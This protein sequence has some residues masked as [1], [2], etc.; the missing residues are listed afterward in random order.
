[1]G[2]NKRGPALAAI[3]GLCL[4]AACAV[5]ERPP[6][7]PLD[8]TP[9][10]LVSVRPDS[11]TTGLGDTKVLH[12]TFSEKM[13]RKSA[14]S[15]LFFYPDQMVRKTKWDGA[16]E[17]EVFLA[18][19]LPPDTVIVIEV[20]AGQQDMHR[21]PTRR[22]RS[23][24]LATA[25]ELPPGAIEG[26]LAMGDSA[27][28]RGV[29]EL[30][31][32]PPDS[33]EYF[34]QRLLRRATTDAEGKFRFD[35]LPAPGGPWLLR[36][37]VDF[38]RDRRLAENEP[39]RLLP[40]TVRVSASDP[41]VSVG[42][43]T[44][45]ARNTPGSLLYDPFPLPAWPGQVLAWT[46][47]VSESDT[48]WAPRPI[49]AGMQIFDLLDPVAGGEIA[50]VKPGDLRLAAFVDVDGDSTFSAISDSVL[51]LAPDSEPG[52]ARW[53]LEPWQLVEGLS[54]EPGLQGKLTMSTFPDSLTPWV[55]PP[56]PSTI[57]ETAADSL[58]SLEDR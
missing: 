47:A 18:E 34:Q 19:V 41:R 20:A 45:Y 7:G 50:Q 51:G 1:M 9:P 35:W 24:P 38:N 21:V 36:A 42:V 31:D 32:V 43:T 16:K 5:V 48:G 40:D 49:A 11:G 29:V 55:A 22:S 39:G 28:T 2:S 56:P 8:S 46:M 52:E 58:S 33:L 54:V 25:G 57:Q 27:V 4:L 26:M 12:F 23:F 6:G 53:F 15:W 3:A 37:F 17:A 10:H 30:Y 13:D 14:T 44:L